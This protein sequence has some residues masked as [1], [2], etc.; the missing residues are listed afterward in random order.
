MPLTHNVSSISVSNS[1]SGVI[2]FIDFGI[3]DADQT[4]CT[5]I[6]TFFSEASFGGIQELVSITT[7]NLIFQQAVIR[8]LF[9]VSLDESWESDVFQ[10]FM[11]DLANAVS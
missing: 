7:I 9:D 5:A 2:A 8:G 10:L 3:R 1:S 6:P 11:G 4:N